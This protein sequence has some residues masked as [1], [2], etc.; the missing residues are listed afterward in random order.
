[1]SNKTR[2]ENSSMFHS[3][4]ELKWVR[5]FDHDLVHL[6]WMN[7]GVIEMVMLML[8][9]ND[10]IQSCVLLTSNK[11]AVS[12]HLAWAMSSLKNLR[13]EAKTPVKTKYA[14]SRRCLKK[15]CL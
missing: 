6:D 10:V 8:Y 13:L 7:L 1:M 9:T 3:L 14:Y 12:L 4:A 11:I 2:I 5:A 15:E